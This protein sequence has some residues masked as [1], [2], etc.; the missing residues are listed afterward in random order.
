MAAR[1]MA[2]VAIVATVAAFVVTRRSGVPQPSPTVPATTMLARQLL[3]GPLS[4]G[5]STTVTFQPGLNVRISEAGRSA[6]QGDSARDLIEFTW[7]DSPRQT[8]RFVRVERVYNAR[9]TVTT[10]DQ[11]RL[12]AEPAPTDP[13]AWLRTRTRLTA[14][15]ASP[16]LPAPAGAT[17]GLRTD[18]TVSSGYAFGGCPTQCA[19]LSR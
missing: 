1:I 18:F 16:V 4:L 17:S 19:L 15:E 11:A 7:S 3:A 5:D 10:S 13:A 6:P 9:S 8:V 12:A 2:V 14:T